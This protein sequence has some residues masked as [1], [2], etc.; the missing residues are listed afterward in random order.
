MKTNLLSYILAAGISP[1]VSVVLLLPILSGCAGQSLPMKAQLKFAELPVLNKPVRLTATFTW[2][3]S[4][5]PSVNGTARII[6]PE[7]FE[8]V[9]G[10]TGW[11]GLLVPG[12]T[13]TLNATVKAVKLGNWTIE[14]R[15]DYFV[16]AGHLGGNNYLY[17]SVSERGATVSDRSPRDY[18]PSGGRTYIPGPS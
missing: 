2:V 3:D 12:D 7:G 13:L 17:V 15:T 5:G 16:A 18:G 9:D 8:R 6:L 11:E 4:K 10:N 14:A 1:V